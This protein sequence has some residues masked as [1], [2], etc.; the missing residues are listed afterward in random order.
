MPT[1]RSVMPLPPEHRITEAVLAMRA[2]LEGALSA[3]DEALVQRSALAWAMHLVTLR[4]VAARGL[5]PAHPSPITEAPTEPTLRPLPD[6]LQR[7]TTILD[8]TRPATGETD[9]FRA[10]DALGWAYQ[11]WNSAEKSR[12]FEAIRV[13]KVAKVEGGDLVSATGIYTPSH[14][15][16]LLLQGSLGARYLAMR[17][18]SELRRSWAYFVEDPSPPPSPRR[19]VRELRVLDPACGT[20]H[21]LIEAFDLLYAMYDEEGSLADPSAIC[22]AIFERNLHGIDIDPRAVEIARI[23]LLLRARERAPGFVPGRLQLVA[24][25]FPLP[26]AP[27]L[28]DRYLAAH[29]GDAPLAPALAAIFT[30]FT[31]AGDLGSLLRVEEPLDEALGPG[32]HAAQKRAILAR[33][34]AFLDAEA[35]RTEAPSA[36][37]SSAPS[38]L[39]DLL[40]RRY[41]VVC[42][43]PPYVGFRKLAPAIKEKIAEDPLAT[44]DLYVAFLARFFS[45]LD[46]GG[47][48][49]AVTPSSWTTSSRTEGLRKKMLDEGGPRI[50]VSL[51]QRIFPSAPL[52]FV[53]LSII[54]KGRAGDDALTTLRPAPA[55]GEAGLRQAIAR[56]HPRWPHALLRSLPTLPFFPVAPLSLL[57]RARGAP[58]VQDFFTF[59]D[60]LWTGSNDRDIRESWEVD[61]DDRAWLPTSGGQ[62]YARWYAPLSRRM[63]A[64]FAEGWPVR[65]A[66]ASALEYARVAGGKLSALILSAPSLA[67]AGI[68]S[69]L[70]RQGTDSRRLAECAAVFNCRLGTI[71]VRT[72]TSGL[73]F[74]PGYAG[75]IPLAAAPPPPALGEAVDRL[76]E[77]K[78]SLAALDLACDDFS[79][80]RFTSAARPALARWAARTAEVALSITALALDDEAA[81]EEQLRDH[82]GINAGAWAEIEAELGPPV[83]ALPPLL[84]ATEE[85]D[86]D[87]GEEDGDGEA[88]ARPAET[89]LEALSRAQGASPR[90]LLTSNDL[91]PTASSA[92]TALRASL[93]E[94]A[95]EDYLLVAILRL[96]GHRWPGERERPA[97][98]IAPPALLSI[99][100]GGDEPTLAERVR[101][102][103]E[104]GL[105]PLERPALRRELDAVLGKGLDRWIENGFFR[106]LLVRFRRRPILWQIQSGKLRASRRP[107]V[108]VIV[109]A[110]RLS[111]PVLQE[112]RARLKRSGADPKEIA[113]FDQRLTSLLDRGFDAPEL[114]AILAGEPLD[115]FT[116][117]DGIAPP[118]AS[119][120]AFLAQERRYLPAP[121]DGVRVNIAPVQRAGLLAAEVLGAGDIDHAIADRARFRAEERRLCREG[122]LDRPGYWPRLPTAH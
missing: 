101:A 58:T 46:E 100:P 24:T 117:I 9:P 19:E 88:R 59:S 112:I 39:L 63:R 3:E 45:L 90:F 92:V 1:S 60:G 28:S 68:V 121:D 120:E 65:D 122:K 40:G 8:G 48:L 87:A 42:M 12:L 11:A 6:V 32:D 26:S 16:Q 44:L 116:S 108:A 67:I 104:H 43:N 34:G 62:G 119:F 33:I 118:P 14:L 61:P 91:P 105:P 15:V 110:H 76:V 23:S 80:A 10:P 25:R 36:A 85:S 66:R 31:L 81:V 38:E 89:A 103:L 64:R 5:D 109:H 94:R 77:H 7:C 71:W 37:R 55:S 98:P 95:L 84:R 83:A 69:I 114:P 78:R 21:F 75:R 79:P 53:S 96:F 27:A 72:S 70:P 56:P 107:A 41:D 102:A 99:L 113:D 86:P 115:R 106:H 50:M 29:P 17:P 20:G 52:L 49:A 47:S 4:C 54:D 82:L 35:A 97:S 57:E 51:G 18:R 22:A 30:A 74:N 73:N 13:K 93:A 2:L 111:A